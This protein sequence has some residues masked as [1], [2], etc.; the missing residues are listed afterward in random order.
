MNIFK[1]LLH[2]AQCVSSIEEL[3]NV[4]SYLQYEFGDEMTMGISLEELLAAVK[5]N[6]FVKKEDES[7]RVKRSKTTS[8]SNSNHIGCHVRINP[9]YIFI[10]NF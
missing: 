2:K 6:D 8:K 1:L 10:F 4:H 3:K 9:C 7:K 5:D